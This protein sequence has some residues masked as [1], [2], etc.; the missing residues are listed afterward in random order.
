[1]SRTDKVYI[2]DI[3]ESIDL[4]EKYTLEITEH[5]FS[6]DTQ[7]QDAVIRRFEIIG[8]A[9]SKISEA[10]KAR[11]PT[12]QWKLMKLMRNKLIHEYFGVSAQTIYATLIADLPV[13]KAQLI[14]LKQTEF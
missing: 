11:Y 7:L 8:E 3:I 6:K 5:Q 14:H 2:E 1:M 13:L 10:L 9:S 4:I 12:T